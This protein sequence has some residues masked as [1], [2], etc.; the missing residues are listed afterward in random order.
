M[1][2]TSKESKQS[3]IAEARREQIVEAAIKTLDEIGYVSAS[4]SQIAKRAGIST[5]LI[6]YHFADKN[7]LM[8]DLI[9]RLLEQSSSYILERVSRADTAREKLRL[10]IEASLAYQGTHPARNAALLEI[11]FNGRT[12]DNI[13]YYKIGDDDEEDL[14]VTEL[15]RIL[16]EGQQ[17]GEF[18]AFHV[19]VMA[20]VIQGAIGEYMSYTGIT[21]RVDLE[22]Y[23]NELVE[24]VSKAVRE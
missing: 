2:E 13:P 19:D 12:P 18:G 15:K 20:S 3:F 11:I 16:G 23:A 9:M 1:K 6:S 8:N 14:V 4:L 24:I 22:T 17:N 5:A 10:F 21:K 7:D